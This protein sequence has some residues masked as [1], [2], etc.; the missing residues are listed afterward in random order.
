M[1][2]TAFE[3]AMKINPRPDPRHRIEHGYFPSAG[4]LQRMK[5]SK[6]ILSTQPQ[7]ISWHG[8]MYVQETNSATIDMMLPLKTMI[9]MGIPVAFGCDVPASIYQ[10]PKYAFT[11]S[12]FRRTPSGV[13]LNPDQRLTVREALRTHTLGSAYASYSENMTGS[14]EPGKY[15]DLVVWSHDLYTMPPTD[16]LNLKSEMTIVNG[17]IAYSSGTLSVTTTLDSEVATGAYPELT[18]GY[19]NPFVNFTTFR[20]IVPSVMSLELNIYDETGR[21]VRTLE[22]NS[23]IPGSYTAYWDGTD[24]QGLKVT[25]GIYICSLKSGK[26]LSQKKIVR[27]SNY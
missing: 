8:D 15:A 3:A 10:E 2:L 26:S 14:L 5:T 22:N 27:I 12:I 16:F 11:G 23:F 24:D 6:I 19:P 7:W 25:C 17:D 20:F 13:T 4:A 18:D 1:T 21:K 9:N